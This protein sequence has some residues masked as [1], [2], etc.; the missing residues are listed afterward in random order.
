MVIFLILFVD[1]QLCIPLFLLPPFLSPP[2]PASILFSILLV[3]HTSCPEFL[4]SSIH[5]ASIPSCINPVLHLSCPASILYCIHPVLHASI[6]SSIYLVLYYPVQPTSCLA[7]RLLSSLPPVLPDFCP[8]CHL[9]CL[10][11]TALPASG[12][13]CLVTNQPPVLPTSYSAYLL[14]SIVSV[15]S[16]SD[17]HTA[18]KINMREIF[19]KI[20]TQA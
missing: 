12:P 6:I 17:P 11:L 7:Y 18:R 1:V 14:F 10:P 4:L 2:S 13:A 9:S 3:L 16:N 20:S 15:Q 5:P 19:L 8:A